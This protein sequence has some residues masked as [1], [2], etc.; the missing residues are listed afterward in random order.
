MFL[1]LLG[2]MFGARLMD[3]VVPDPIAAILIGSLGFMALYAAWLWAI[4]AAASQKLDAALRASPRWMAIGLLYAAVYLTGALILLSGASESGRGVPGFV[5][6]MHLMA[7]FAVFYALAFTAKMLVTLE[8]S[9]R[10]TFF[11][12]SGPFFLFWFFPIGVWFVQP[13]V[14][15]LLGSGN[16]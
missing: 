9:Q 4:A 8:R 16:A 2:S 7:M 11:D 6:P 13:R 15:K 5:V 14:N 10:V 12:Y 3:T 1:V